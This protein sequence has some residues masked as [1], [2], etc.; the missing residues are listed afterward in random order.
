MIYLLGPRYEP[1]AM[2]YMGDTVANKA[3]EVPSRG[4]HTCAAGGRQQLGSDHAQ[5][6]NPTLLLLAS[7][8]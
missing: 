5:M 3:D 4:P 6:A 1:D 8:P 7:Q 2:L